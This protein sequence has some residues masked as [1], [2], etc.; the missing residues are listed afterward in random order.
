M[1]RCE[2]TLN[3]GCAH[4]PPS[5]VYFR[6]EET[7]PHYAQRLF[8]PQQFQYPPRLHSFSSFRVAG[9]PVHEWLIGG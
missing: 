7:P 6:E 3:S 9:P 1:L 5:Q 2:L 8:S 4:R